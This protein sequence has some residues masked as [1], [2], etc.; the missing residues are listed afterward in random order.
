MCLSMEARTYGLGFDDATKI[1]FEQG[2]S[3]LD[4]FQNK[5]TKA[6]TKTITKSAFIHQPSC[7][8]KVVGCLN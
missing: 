3:C 2:N 6:V 1:H 5:I 8:W 7:N 4:I